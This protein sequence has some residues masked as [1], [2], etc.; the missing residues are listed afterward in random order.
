M[1]EAR[2]DRGQPLRPLRKG[3][4]E[5]RLEIYRLLVEMADRVSQRRQEANGFYLSINTLLVGG[6]AYLG[7][8]ASTERSIVLISVAGLAI[9]LLWVRNIGSYKTLNAAKFTVITDLE[10]RMVE[11][12]FTAEWEELDPD[13]DG[14]RHKPFHKVE[15]LVPWIFAVVYGIQLLGQIPF[16]QLISCLKA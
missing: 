8:F 12:P 3:E 15:V 5:E 13:R 6:S 2:S 4:A 11:Q 7:T 16:E 1:S 14:D 9:C 10:K